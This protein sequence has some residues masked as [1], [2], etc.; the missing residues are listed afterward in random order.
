MVRHKR[1]KISVRIVILMS[2]P[3]AMMSKIHKKANTE[4][5][6]WYFQIQTIISAN[7]QLWL[8]PSA[9]AII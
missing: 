5:T 3:L 8:V 4:L 9:I 7:I 2:F 1:F 6:T